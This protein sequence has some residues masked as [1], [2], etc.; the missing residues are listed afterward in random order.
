[1]R[2]TSARLWTIWNKRIDCWE[3]KIPPPKHRQLGAERAARQDVGPYHRRPSVTARASLMLADFSCNY[4]L[5]SIL[6]K[7]ILGGVPSNSIARNLR[8]AHSSIRSRSLMNCA[9]RW[10]ALDRATPSRSSHLRNGCK[11]GGRRVDLDARQ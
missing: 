3:G 9:S 5:K 11:V 4:V 2:R 7:I 8:A 10:L 1:M 6:R